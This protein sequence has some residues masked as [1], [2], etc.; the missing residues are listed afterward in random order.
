[1]SATKYQR[2][3]IKIFAFQRYDSEKAKIFFQII[4]HYQ[5]IRINL[6]GSVDYA[7]TSSSTLIHLFDALST[8]ESIKN[9][10]K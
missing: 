10:S 7:S 1:L 2:G 8:I 4:N 6:V 3:K 5:A 9:Y